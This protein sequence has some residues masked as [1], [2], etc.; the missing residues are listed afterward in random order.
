MSRKEKLIMT[1][2]EAVRELKEWAVNDLS[3]IYG[4]PPLPDDIEWGKTPDFNTVTCPAC[5]ELIL[6][7]DGHMMEPNRL[8]FICPTCGADFLSEGRTP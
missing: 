6:E 4:L 3:G 2:R 5:G 1:T 7:G 8:K